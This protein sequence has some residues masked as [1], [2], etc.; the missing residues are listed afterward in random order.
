M[1]WML[2][3]LTACC[4]QSISV[5]YSFSVPSFVT[6]TATTRSRG[7]IT[8]IDLKKSIF[9]N[10]YSSSDGSTHYNVGN[11]VSKSQ[12][13]LWSRS[14]SRYFMNEV[15]VVQTTKDEAIMQQQNAIT[16]AKTTSDTT[17]SASVALIETTMTPSLIEIIKRDQP[18]LSLP[19]NENTISSTTLQQDNNNGSLFTYYVNFAQQ[20]PNVNN[21]M[22]ATIKTSIADLVAQTIIGGTSIYDIDIQRNI[23]FCIFGGLYLGAF[24]YYYQVQIFKKLFPSIEQFTNQSIQEKLQDISGLRALGLQTILDLT[25]LTIIYLPAFYIFKA[26]VFSGTT[27]PIQWVS[28]GIDNYQMNFAKDEYNLIRVWLPADI[29]CF[30]VPLYLR[31]PVRHIVSFVWTAY[32]SFARGGH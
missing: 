5:A 22:I 28:Y 27:D 15:I 6:T 30:S 29:V 21:I 12:S 31:L 32:L 14:E 26:S 1:L 3:I 19:T 20:Y 2:I 25:V 13:R 9:H 24:Q 18:E 4:Y 7:I 11:S 17:T 10:K 8:I 16:S 23:L